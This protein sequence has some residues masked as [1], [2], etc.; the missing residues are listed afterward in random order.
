MERTDKELDTLV[1]FISEDFGKL[2]P[3]GMVDVVTAMRDSFMYEASMQVRNLVGEETADK[4]LDKEE[5]DET[6]TQ[7]VPSLDTKMIAQLIH[8]LQ[9]INEIFFTFESM[10]EAMDALSSCIKDGIHERARNN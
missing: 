1:Q 9:H 8:M 4:L 7:V 6:L 10:I 3:W 5:S 2:P